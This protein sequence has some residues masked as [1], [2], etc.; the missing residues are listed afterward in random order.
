M[1]ITDREL[2]HGIETGEEYIWQ[3]R[4]HILKN[5]SQIGEAVELLWDQQRTKEG[6]THRTIP[7]EVISIGF[8]ALDGTV[9]TISTD[10]ISAMDINPQWQNER[11]QST[12]V[13]WLRIGE[14]T[15]QAE[16]KLGRWRNFSLLSNDVFVTT[17][18]NEAL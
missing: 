18:R 9:E 15:E 2:L 6:S 16:K 13:I 12:P 5:A 7:E 3:M 8:V 14:S 4:D 10:V 1:A 11:T 17:V